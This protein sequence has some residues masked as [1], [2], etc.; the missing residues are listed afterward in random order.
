MPCCVSRQRELNTTGCTSFPVGEPSPHVLSCPGF[1]PRRPPNPLYTR[2]PAHYWLSASH[3]Q[4]LQPRNRAL[5]PTRI[6]LL[7]VKRRVP[8]GSC[9][10]WNTSAAARSQEHVPVDSLAARPTMLHLLQALIV[11]DI[12]R[13]EPQGSFVYLKWW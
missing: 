8:G 7:S 2:S 6:V 4:Q 1:F 13:I 10:R 5:L 3:H 9:T 11:R 12:A